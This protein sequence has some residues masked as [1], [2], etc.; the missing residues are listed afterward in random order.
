MKK[1]ASTTLFFLSKWTGMYRDCEID[2]SFFLRLDVGCGVCSMNTTTKHNNET[3]KMSFIHSTWPR[4]KKPFKIVPKVKLPLETRK[5]AVSTGAYISR[6]FKSD[7]QLKKWSSKEEWHQKMFEILTWIGC[8]WLFDFLDCSLLET[9]FF[10][11]RLW[12][13]TWST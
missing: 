7:V 11:K 5:R 10:V 3:L 12:S 8:S 13:K 4:H 2:S 6:T 1:I 9:D